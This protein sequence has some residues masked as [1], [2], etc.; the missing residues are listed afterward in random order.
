MSPCSALCIQYCGKKK[1]CCWGVACEGLPGSR[2]WGEHSR[3][4]LPSVQGYFHEHTRVHW[5]YKESAVISVCPPEFRCG[6]ATGSSLPKGSTTISFS[7]W[8]PGNRREGCW[9]LIDEGPGRMHAHTR[10]ANTG[11][12]SSTCHPQ[13]PNH[14]PRNKSC[15]LVAPA[16]QPLNLCMHHDQ[17]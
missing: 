13:P 1:V 12:K 9:S 10:A 11:A 6:D 15:A 8:A 16:T 14:E 3:R 17:V 7:C 4:T 5:F 2:P